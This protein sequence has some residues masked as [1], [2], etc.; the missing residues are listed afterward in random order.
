MISKARAYLATA[1]V[2]GY[3]DAMW[4][5][6]YGFMENHSLIRTEWLYWSIAAITITHIMLF[7]VCVHK[8]C[9]EGK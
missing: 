8:H 1:F 4:F 9:E 6:A 7:I 3:L 5:L 2:V